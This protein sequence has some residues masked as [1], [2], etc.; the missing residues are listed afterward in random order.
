MKKLI[1]FFFFSFCFFFSF[2]DQ[3]SYTADKETVSQH[4]DSLNLV[5]S[6]DFQ[7][8]EVVMAKINNYLFKEKKLLTR[9]LSLSKY[10]FPIFEIFLDKYNLPLELKYLAVVESSLNTRAQSQSGARGL[11]QFMYP[12]GKAYDLNVTSYVDERLDP[13]KSTEAACKYF[14]KLYDIFG[15]WSLVLAAYNGG[16]GYVQRLMLKTG[17]ENY[18]DLRN[19]LRSETK[20]YVPKFIAITYLM[21]YHEKYDIYPDTTTINLLNTDTL[22][23][24]FQ[25]SSKVLSEL[26]CISKDEI[27]YYNPAFK[28]DIFPINS[29]ISLPKNSVDDFFYNYESYKEFTEKVHKKEILI[30]ETRIVYSVVSG[31]YLGKIAKNHN[32]KIHQIQ[33]WNGLKTT[34]LNIG[35]KL[36]LYVADDVLNDIN[37]VEPSKIL[38]IVQKGDT[39]WDIAKMYSGVSIEKIKKLNKLDN[40]NLK[41]GSRL[42]IPKV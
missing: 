22:L 26:T 33:K 36:V 23:I 27:R 21:T 42:L 38:H 19:D 10:Y 18:W 37:N 12:T 15:D 32:I 8:N 17:F 31:D 4:L 40:N 3:L 5:S 7:N 28:D 29:I 11:W 35:D 6:F 20:N 2:S 34:K 41:P 16:P 1:F 39:L 30:D 14:L 13:F 25:I 9:M 24:D